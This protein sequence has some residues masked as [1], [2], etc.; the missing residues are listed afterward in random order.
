MFV[1]RAQLL[2][3]ATL[4]KVSQLTLQ[5][6]TRLFTNVSFLKFVCSSSVISL[7]GVQ[8]NANDVSSSNM[9]ILFTETYRD[10]P[11]QQY[12]NLLGQ[13]F[14]SVDINSL[15][16]NYQ[17]DKNLVQILQNRHDIWIK[18][19]PLKDQIATLESDLNHLGDVLKTNSSSASTATEKMTVHSP[20]LWRLSSNNISPNSH[21]W[22]VRPSSCYWS[23]RG[24]TILWTHS[25]RTPHSRS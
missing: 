20:I 13:L 5:S 4:R 11:L 3:T 16:N 15:S 22:R 9:I 18:F 6:R 1:S 8:T 21:H 7:R 14:S 10:P 23:T 25:P 17:F 12:V 24:L 19:L 2:A